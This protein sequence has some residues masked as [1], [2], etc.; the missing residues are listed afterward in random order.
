[1]FTCTMCEK[2]SSRVLEFNEC[3]HIAC[4]S[5]VANLIWQGRDDH[6][7]CCNDPRCPKCEAQTDIIARSDTGH[8]QTLF[9]KALDTDTKCG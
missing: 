3:G 4:D 7:L 5:C 8:F 1:M 9:E 6:F 2:D